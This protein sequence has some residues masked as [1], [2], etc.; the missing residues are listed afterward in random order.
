[1]LT[2]NENVD[3]PIYYYYSPHVIHFPDSIT[4]RNGIMS[5]VSTQEFGILLY[6]L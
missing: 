5:S 4:V 1:M 6:Q 2:M 3:F